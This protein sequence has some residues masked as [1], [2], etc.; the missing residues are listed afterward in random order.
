MYNIFGD[1]PYK[2][3][4]AVSEGFVTCVGVWKDEYPLSHGNCFSLKADDGN[5][6]RILNFVYENFKKLLE[7]KVLSYPVQIMKLTDRHAVVHDV[8]I[9][10]DWYAQ[11]FCEVCCPTSLLPLP[12]LLR[13]D[14]DERKGTRITTIHEDGTL[15]IC[16]CIQP[17]KQ[18][19]NATWTIEMEDPEILYG[20]G[21]ED[22]ITRILI[23]EIKEIDN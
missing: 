19:L 21:L 3:L 17:S 16:K 2:V 22:E 20:I 18:K 15:S 11:K 9:E 12:Q 23:K 1:T 6:Y 10:N 13:H 4:N 8:R 14:R 5:Y 7:R